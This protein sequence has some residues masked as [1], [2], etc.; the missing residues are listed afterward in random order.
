MLPS[1]PSNKSEFEFNKEVEEVK[2]PVIKKEVDR[3]EMKLRQER[4]S[5]IVQTETSKYYQ[6]LIPNMVTIASF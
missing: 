4:L 3:E 2:E 5:R 6:D 1:L